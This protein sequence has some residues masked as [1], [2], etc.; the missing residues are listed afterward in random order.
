MGVIGHIY[1]M[2]GRGSFRGGGIP[3]LIKSLTFAFRRTEQEL[4]IDYTILD[5]SILMRSVYIMV[6]S[7]MVP[8]DHLLNLL[9]KIGIPGL[10]GRVLSVIL[11]AIQQL[12]NI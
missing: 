5:S 10:A 2:G 7:V 3:L 9:M 11:N 4:R 1:E 12:S 8:F 6:P